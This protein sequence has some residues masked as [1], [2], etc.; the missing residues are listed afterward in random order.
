MEMENLNAVRIQQEK[1]EKVLNYKEE[2]IF[3]FYR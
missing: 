3:S 2:K 1:R